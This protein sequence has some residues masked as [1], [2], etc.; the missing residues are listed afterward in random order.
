M[1]IFKNILTCVLAVLVSTLNTSTEDRDKNAGTQGC[2]ED[3]MR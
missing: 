2:G 1:E 3:H